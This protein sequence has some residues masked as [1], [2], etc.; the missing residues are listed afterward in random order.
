MQGTYQ[1]IDAVT[2]DDPNVNELRLSNKNFTHKQR[3]YMLK[4]F[5][6][7]MIVRDPLERLVSAYRNK[8]QD[9]NNKYYSL[10]GRS[11]VQRYRYNNKRRAAPEDNATFT[12]YVRYLID[13][14]SWQIDEH[15]KPYEE[16]CRPCNIEYNFIG[17]IDNLNR[18]IRYVLKQI[19]ANESRY[20]LSNKGKVLIKTKQSTASF[21]KELPKNYFDQL[22]AKY[23]NDHELFDYPLPDYQTL[24]KRYRV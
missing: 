24:D 19:Q 4:N 6:K 17:T 8:L 20:F 22:L 11:M 10:V 14:P 7:F 15:W 3:E 21:L 9:K 1:S 12:E 16:L 23:E 18:D 2:P 13:H 5:Y